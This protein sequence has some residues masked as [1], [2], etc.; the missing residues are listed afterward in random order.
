MPERYLIV[1]EA[2]GAVSIA[3][4][5]PASLP[6]ATAKPY[7]IVAGAGPTSGAYELLGRPFEDESEVRILLR[8]SADERQR[9]QLEELLSVGRY[10]EAHWQGLFSN[11]W[12]DEHGFVTDAGE[13]ALGGDS[14]GAA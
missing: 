12:I 13:E 3:E 11:G 6:A 10:R 14:P 4:D 7:R 1:A 2:D 9:H 5:L 8:A